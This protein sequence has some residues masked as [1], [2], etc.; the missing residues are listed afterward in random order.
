MRCVFIAPPCRAPIIGARLCGRR[1]PTRRHRLVGWC[2]DASAGT[3][4]LASRGSARAGV[5][6]NRPRRRRLDR[7]GDGTR[8][9]RRF[10]VNALGF[11]RLA[12]AAPRYNRGPAA[13]AHRPKS[14]VSPASAAL[15]R[16]AILFMVVAA[17]CWSSGGLLVRQLS[18]V[19]PWEIGSIKCDDAR[20]LDHCHFPCELRLGRGQR[21]M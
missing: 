20:P 17:T 15:H 11:P 4:R 6:C 18:I 12:R 16:R 5:H 1:V 10:R 3:A 9:G 14:H 2:V 7:C 8:S 13:F 21:R 19:D